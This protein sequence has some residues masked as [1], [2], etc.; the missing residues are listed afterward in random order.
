MFNR[1]LYYWFDNSHNTVD[2]QTFIQQLLRAVQDKELEKKMETLGEGLRNLWSQEALQ[3][4]LE[5]GLER[6]RKEG[7]KEGR[8]EGLRKSSENIAL[9]LLKMQYLTPE[10]VAKVTELP[11]ETIKA[12]AADN[13]S[14]SID[15]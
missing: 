2:N 15:T 12:L 14:E 11:L 3:Q 4:G 10:Q 7:R 6:G 5:Q 9:N 1:I 13:A 8:M